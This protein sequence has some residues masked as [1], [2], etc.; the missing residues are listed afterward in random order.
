MRAAVARDP[1]ASRASA[2]R[3][4]GTKFSTRPDT[5]DVDRAV[6]ERQRSAVAL[7]RSAARRRE[8]LPRRPEEAFRRLDAS[9]RSG[10]ALLEDRGAQRPRPAADVEPAPG[11]GHRQPGKKARRDLAAPAADVPLVRV[12][13]LPGVRDSRVHG[14]TVAAP[15]PSA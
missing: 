10:R 12:S 1:R 2:R 4:S 15:L 13:A 5:T 7:V 11:R 6:L 9:H 8:V 3:G 14:A